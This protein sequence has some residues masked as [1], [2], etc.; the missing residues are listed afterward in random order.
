[1]ATNDTCTGGNERVSDNFRCGDCGGAVEKIGAAPVHKG[2]NTAY[3]CLQCGSR[4]SVVD[5]LR[6]PLI[7]SGLERVETDDLSDTEND[8]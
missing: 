6:Q 4:G 1:M 8:Q 7:I 2:S 3:R 5:R